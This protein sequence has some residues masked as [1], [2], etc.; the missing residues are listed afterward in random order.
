MKSILPFLVFFCCMHSVSAQT[1]SDTDIDLLSSELSK[2]AIARNALKLAVL[3]FTE[4]NA[5]TDFSLAV[6]EW[7]YGSDGE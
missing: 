7:K 2:Q 6:S 3:D 4:S 1:I 5:I